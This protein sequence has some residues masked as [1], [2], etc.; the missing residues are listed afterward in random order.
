[1]TREP[2]PTRFDPA[3]VEAKWQAEWRRRGAFRAPDEPTGRTFSLILP[4]PNVTSVLTIGH[5]M[6]DTIMDILVRWHRMRG[7]AV[8]WAPGVDHAGLAT[9]TAV[10]KALAKDGI[11]LET[12]PREEILRHVEAWK[13]EREARIRHQID[14]AGFSV[15]WSRYRYTMDAGALRA[16]REVFVHLY[17]DGL[18]YRGERIVNWDP[19]LRTAIS[20]LEVLHREED[21]ELLTIRYAWADGSPGGLSVA[22]VRAETIF[23]DVA[24]A[25]HPDDA[26]H[27]GAVGRAVRVPLTDR[28][29]P[30]IADAAVDPAF[31][32]G[33]VKVTPRHDPLDYQ[34]YRAH[35]N[36]LELLP[37]ILDLDGRMTGDLVPGEF[38]GIDR[39][40]A[41]AAVATALDAAGAVERRQPY[42]HSVG[43]SERSDAVVEPLLSTQWFVRTSALAAPAV[44]AVRDGSVRLHPARWERTFYSWMEQLDDWCISRQVVWGHPIPVYYCPACGAEAAALEPPATCARCAHADLRPDPDVLDTWFTSWLWPFVNLGWP[45]TTRDLARYYPT[46]VLVTGRDIMFFWVARMMMAG[47]RFTG[48]P[49]FSDVYFSGLLR[50]E[51]GRKISKSLGNSPDPLDLIRERGADGLRFALVHPGPVDQDGPFTPGTLD[52][53]RNF[54]TKLWNVV[55]FVHGNLAEGAAPPTAAPAL[56]AGAP[57]EHRWILHRWRTM[58]SEVDR[59]LAA[60]EFS[61]AASA[62]YQ[63]LWHDLADVYLEWSRGDLAGGNGEAAALTARQVLTFVTERTVRALHPFVPHVTEELWQALP[64]SGDLLALAP[65]PRAD[66]APLD[67]EAEVAV[68]IVLEA[69]RTLRHLRSEH[70][71]PLTASPEGFVRPSGP[72][73]ENL[74]N[75]QREVVRRLAKLGTLTTLEGSGPAPPGTRG[76]VR[77]SGEYFLAVPETAPSSDSLVRERE[78]LT[79]LLAKTEERL[80]DAGF[81][82]R[83]PPPSSPRRRRRPAS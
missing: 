51:L 28:T 23:G 82:S 74:L 65:W 43:R 38:R 17:N 5:M 27:A 30:V 39:E 70:H 66:E 72:G 7:E 6:G 54:L 11:R 18:V 42:R 9:Q 78:L 44:A 4:P 3:A 77:P 24:V 60:F 46:S 75:A 22:T 34:I 79:S 20:D 12:L 68:G 41:R 47:Y 25:V 76:T 69:V 62:L 48:Q 26:R 63:F 49:P 2:L 37:T 73:A 80:A 35:A 61:E 52:G 10:R 8:L 16:T 33:A 31:G 21:T 81:R 71:V 1:M 56:P 32:T 50:D 45:E 19:R 13:V 58:Q 57:I 64:H 55:R 40:K 36:E 67:P 83:A 53:G 14:A 29:I 59:A 15:D